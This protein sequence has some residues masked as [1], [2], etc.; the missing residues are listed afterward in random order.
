MLAGGIL[1][2][3]P[4]GQNA[5]HVYDQLEEQC[6]ANHAFAHPTNISARATST[7]YKQHHEHMNTSR[8]TNHTALPTPT[9]NSTFNRNILAQ[10]NSF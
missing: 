5:T 8:R 7:H 1:E 2:E 9:E 4:H 3:K 10:T 6:E